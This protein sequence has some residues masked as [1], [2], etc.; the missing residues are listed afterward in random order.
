MGEPDGLALT[1]HLRQRSH[2]RHVDIFDIRK[3]LETGCVTAD[4]WDENHQNWKYRVCGRDTEGDSL[5]VV[6]VIHEAAG[7]IKVITAHD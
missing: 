4:S 6:V 5:T 2:E 7:I 3:A 1:H